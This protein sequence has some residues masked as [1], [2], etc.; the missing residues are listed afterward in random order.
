[1]QGIALV[2]CLLMML[3]ILLL[4][5]SGA[6]IALQEEKA[7]RFERDRM[8]AFQAAEA[9]LRD[10]EIDIER[11]GRLAHFAAGQRRA[12]ECG[13]G[14][15]NPMLGL[16]RP[17][18]PELFP[19]WQKIALGREK[20]SVP[21]GHITG[22]VLSQGD[23]AVPPAYLIE[24]LGEPAYRI[25]AI[26]YGTSGRTQVVL[27][28]YFNKPAKGAGRRLGWREILN[29]EEVREVLEGL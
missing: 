9:A 17:A 7:S 10:A 5:A 2:V 13:A 15:A 18:T 6:Q 11:S 1:M 14:L 3:V 12:G 27:Q 21:Y 25:T 19:V 8:V 28:S 24:V 23:R 26:G 20:I 22:R 4:G 29:W 16:C